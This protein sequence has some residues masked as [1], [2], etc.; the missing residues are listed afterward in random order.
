MEEKMKEKKEEQKH[1]DEQGH[2]E[3]QKRVDIDERTFIREQDRLAREKKHRK[4]R[5]KRVLI[6]GILSFVLVLGIWF[7]V[8]GRDLL[9]A[10]EEVFVQVVAD[11]SQSIIYARLDS[12]YG[13]EIAYTVLQPILGETNAGDT[14]SNG[15]MPGSMPTGAGA[16]EFGDMP[17]GTGEEG[18]GNIPPGAGAE[19]FGD[20]PWRTGEEGAGSMPDRGVSGDTTRAQAALVYDNVSYALS[21]ETREDIIPVGTD[22][23]TRLG[24]V[25]TFSRLRAGD[26]VALVMDG[27]GNKQV[28]AAV[29]VIG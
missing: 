12:V 10:D 5:K 11:A 15:R 26:Y 2:M 23:T 20:M 28:I 4:N 18:T 17:W 27:D 16:E 9:F 19:E 24:T 29:Y 7:F 14:E 6:G 8:W 21:T 3:E 25:S 13:N 22:V 1:M